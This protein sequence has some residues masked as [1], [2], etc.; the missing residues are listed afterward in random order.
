MSLTVLNT[1]E[2]LTFSKFR[3]YS[4]YIWMSIPVI[5]EV[6]GVLNFVK[7]N[8]FSYFVSSMLLTTI[9]ICIILLTFYSKN[10]IYELQD[11]LPKFTKLSEDKAKDTIDL[12]AKR[13]ITGNW[14]KWIMGIIVSILGVMTI[15]K[16]GLPFSS[17][18]NKN[19]TI[20]LLIPIFFFCGTTAYFYL[21][22][23]LLP[24]YISKIGINLV[25]HKDI[26]NGVSS[27][28][29][30]IN[31]LYIYGVSLFVLLFFAI[32]LSPYKFSKVMIIWIS[33]LGIIGILILP[34]SY[35][36]LHRS[37]KKAK[38]DIIYDLSKCISKY[39]NEI[40][41]SY[42]KDSMSIL[43][44]YIDIKNEV[45]NLPEWPINIQTIVTIL[46]TL[47]LPVIAILISIIK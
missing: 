18:L 21:Q 36:G 40:K 9:F 13:I 4:K 27:I 47:L 2:Q 43:K 5:I 16:L 46:S 19:I 44:E 6:I 41:V 45:S 22:V 25:I 31:E 24:Y 7:E 29:K 42:N 26:N 35:I 8:N 38:L 30:I 12:Y 33:I 17:A 15:I 3:K 23:S 20:I 1:Y 14:V 11:I 28:N 39:I 37:M 10:K 34:V 32:L